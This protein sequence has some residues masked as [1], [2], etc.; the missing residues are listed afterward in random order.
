LIA[1]QSVQREFDELEP[2]RRS[3][4]KARAARPSRVR[5]LAKLL[6]TRRGAAPAAEHV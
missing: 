4:S 6:S 3:V 1:V 5:R 2:H